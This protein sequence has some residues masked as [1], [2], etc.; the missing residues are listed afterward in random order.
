MVERVRA[1]Q[2]PSAVA[3]QMG[4]SRQTVHKWV[5]RYAAE[6][7]AARE[8][9]MVVSPTVS[10]PLTLRS[11]ESRITAMVDTAPAQCQQSQ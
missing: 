7:E 3:A 6:G 2:S 4:C 10:S 1:G 5:K 9:A 11:A 8:L